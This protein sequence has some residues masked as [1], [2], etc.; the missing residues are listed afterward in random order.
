MAPI[1][2]QLHNQCRDFI[3]ACDFQNKNLY[4]TTGISKK[5]LIQSP[6][7]MFLAL[8]PINTPKETY[9]MCDCPCK[10]ASFASEISEEIEAKERQRFLANLS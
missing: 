9:H 6:I 3:T 5:L 1:C 10:R 8:F 4:K 2:C 7:F